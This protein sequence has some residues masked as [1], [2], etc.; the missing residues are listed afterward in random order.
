MRATVSIEK[1]VLDELLNATGAKTR[2]AAVRKVIDEYLRKRR[3]E[4]IM[5]MKGKL[6]FDLTA[7]KI[8]HH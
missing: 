1:N 6:S 7:D 4:K 8:R 2:S 5:S 3:V